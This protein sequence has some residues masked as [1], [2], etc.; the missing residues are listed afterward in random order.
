MNI[1]E[2][3]FIDIKTTLFLLNHDENMVFQSYFD[4]ATL[5]FYLSPSKIYNY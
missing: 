2:I 3:P 1:F 5:S 4:F